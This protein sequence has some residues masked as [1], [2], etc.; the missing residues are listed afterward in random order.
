V[1][2]VISAYVR[3][4][5]PSHALSRPEWLVIDRFHR[6]CNQSL[7]RVP[8]LSFTT[9]PFVRV[10][11]HKVLGL[12]GQLLIFIIKPLCMRT[13]MSCPA[14]VLARALLAL[15]FDNPASVIERQGESDAREP[16]KLT[17][18]SG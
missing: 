5:P 9:W 6:V 17:N 1:Q 12:S 4:T 7:K 2:S 8:D 11:L 18:G 14:Q 15:Q 16:P 13:K 10:F 3:L